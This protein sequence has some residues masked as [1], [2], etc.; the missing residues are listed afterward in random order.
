[1]SDIVNRVQQSGIISLNIEEHIPQLA[2]K[3]LDIKDQL[4]HGIALKEKDFRAWIDENNWDEYKG[5]GVAFFCS[6]QVII[7]HW[8]YMLI[9]SKLEGIATYFG[10]GAVGEVKIRFIQDTLLKIDIKEFVDKRVVIKGCSEG[11]I[12]NFVYPELVRLL[13]PH[14]KSV[15]FGEPCSTV[16]VYKRKRNLK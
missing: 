2:W 8:A 15:M 3:E 7:P 10:S 16:P 5:L 13:K 1:M 6:E 9:A 11:E 12:P 4:F 14:T